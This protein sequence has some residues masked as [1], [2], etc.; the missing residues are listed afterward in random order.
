MRK[1]RGAQ[2]CARVVS[3]NRIQYLL[4]TR[5]AKQGV[6]RFQTDDSESWADKHAQSC[7][8]P[9]PHPARSFQSSEFKRTYARQPSSGR[10]DSQPVATT[11][12]AGSSWPSHTLLFSSFERGGYLCIFFLL[13]LSFFFFFLL[14]LLRVGL[15]SRLLLP[16]GPHFRMMFR[17]RRGPAGAG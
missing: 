7:T 8:R 1:S 12:L 10:A 16:Q 17:T 13:L 9:D 3:C 14:L 5:V 11:L 15:A 4:A 2:S 6:K